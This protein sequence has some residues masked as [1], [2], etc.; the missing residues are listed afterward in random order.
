ME[1]RIEEKRKAAGLTQGELAAKI[2]TKTA[3]VSNWENGWATP[4]V[5]YLPKIADVL[6]CTIDALFGRGPQNDEL[7]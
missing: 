5:K 3:S 2:D 4:P 7:S 6:G 1:L